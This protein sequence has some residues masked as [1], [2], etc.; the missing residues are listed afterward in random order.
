MLE[1]CSLPD[2]SLQTFL[3]GDTKPTAEHLVHGPGIVIVV[4]E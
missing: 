2:T 1:A 4:G 3:T